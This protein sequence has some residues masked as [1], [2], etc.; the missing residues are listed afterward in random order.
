MSLG[1]D[2]GIRCVLARITGPSTEM[3]MAPNSND[4]SIEPCK[5]RLT[6]RTPKNRDANKVN[7]AG[8]TWSQCRL[9]E[10]SYPRIDKPDLIILDLPMSVMNGLDAARKLK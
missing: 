1:L 5:V 4:L 9:I 3:K 2:W 7:V 6:R 10:A 8:S